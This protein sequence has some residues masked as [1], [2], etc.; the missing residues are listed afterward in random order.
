MRIALMAVLLAILTAGCDKDSGPAKVTLHPVKGKL[1]RAGQPVKGGYLTLR[2]D[3]HPTLI[4]TAK[5]GD[6][7]TF[8]AMTVDTAERGGNRTTGAPEGTYRGEYGPPGTD[9]SIM[10]V[11]LR[12]PVTI[13]AGPN[14]L[15]IEIG[16]K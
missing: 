1:L 16:K 11:P 8:E 14:D 15:T 2:S 5:V 13:K 4:V 9:Q 6:D 3:G 7:G 10:P 12:E